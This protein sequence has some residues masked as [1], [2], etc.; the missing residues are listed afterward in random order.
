MRM[1]QLTPEMPEL[2]LEMGLNY[3]PQRLAAVLNK[4]WPVVYSRAI[5]IAASLGGFVASIAQDV[6]L[7]NVE[8]NMVKRAGELRD[9]LSGLG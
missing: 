4:R 1:D 9:L 5:L 8:V 3:D 7:G 6:A 2:L